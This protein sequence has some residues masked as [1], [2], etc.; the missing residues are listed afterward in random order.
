MASQVELIVLGKLKDKNLQMIEDDYL[1]RLKNPQLKISELKAQAEDRVSEGQAILKKVADYSQ[2]HLVLLTEDGQEFD[3]KN[4][5]RFVF[6]LIYQ[7]KKVVFAIGGAEGHGEEIRSKCQDKISL[8]KLTFPHKLARIIF[9]EQFYRAVT[10]KE[11][12]PY[13]N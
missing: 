12:H 6:N 3:S 7:G 1:K 8:S 2:L 5:S 9:V 4:F 11:G 13:H 10:I